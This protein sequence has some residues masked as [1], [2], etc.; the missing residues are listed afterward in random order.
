MNPLIREATARP[1]P[2]WPHL[3]LQHSTA[4]AEARVV[5]LIAQDVQRF[6][7]RAGCGKLPCT[8]QAVEGAVASDPGMGTGRRIA[9]KR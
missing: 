6:L 8:G 2:L 7:G 4:P 5:L 1:Q 9:K 3:L